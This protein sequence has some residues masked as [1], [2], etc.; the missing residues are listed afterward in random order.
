MSRLRQFHWPRGFAN[1][2]GT[3]ASSGS[4]VIGRINAVAYEP[5]SASIC[6]TGAMSQNKGGRRRAWLAVLPWAIFAAGLL[7]QAFAPRL[8]IRNNAFVVPPPVVAEG[9]D[10]RP[11]EMITRERRMQLL[12]GILTLGGALGL[13]FRYRH[14][15]VR[16]RSLT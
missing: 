9:K 6:T 10:F 16:P 3:P 8:K 14:V 11:G 1:G 13:G 15:L 5:V 12:S 7:V 4:P 2:A